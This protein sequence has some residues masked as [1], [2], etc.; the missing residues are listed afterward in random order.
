LSEGFLTQS[1]LVRPDS[2]V[3]ASMSFQI[4]RIVE[5]LA[6]EGAQ[7][8]FDVRM[9]FHVPIEQSLQCEALGAQ[10]AREFRIGR[11]RIGLAALALLLALHVLLVFHVQRHFRLLR[12]VRFGSVQDRRVFRLATVHS[13]A[14]D[15][16]IL[17]AVAAVDEF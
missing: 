11:R 17:D 3:R 16:R 2:G 10:S 1:T 14:D 13:I 4:E 15:H 9:T 8:A 5:S 7:I 12:R 6:A